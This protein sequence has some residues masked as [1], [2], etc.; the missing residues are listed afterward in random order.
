MIEHPILTEIVHELNLRAV[1]Y[2][3]GALQSLR[4]EL[5]GF[6]KRPGRSIFSALT[7]SERG[8]FAFHHGGRKELQ[9]NVGL[10]AF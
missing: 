1:N 3:I 10:E 5:K 7:T 6:E 8:Q 4:K 9:F 2:R